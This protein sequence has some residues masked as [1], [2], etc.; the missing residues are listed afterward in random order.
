M[1]KIPSVTKIPSWYSQFSSDFDSDDDSIG[2]NSASASP[3]LLPRSDSPPSWLQGMNLDGKSPPSGE[4]GLSHTKR[5]EVV[6]AHNYLDYHLLT[7]LADDCEAF[8]RVWCEQLELVARFYSTQRMELY[9]QLARVVGSAACIEHSD[10][11]SEE[12]FQC[13]ETDPEQFQTM[14]T[15]LQQL[16]SY[17][18]A[19]AQG[20]SKLLKDP[21]LAATDSA[22]VLLPKLWTSPFFEDSAVSR[23]YSKVHKALLGKEAHQSAQAGKIASSQIT[24][25]ARVQLEF[26]H[27]CVSRV[28]ESV[29][30]H[31]V[32]HRGFHDTQD[33]ISRPIEN[34]LPAFDQAWSSG[35][36]LCE[37]DVSCAYNI[38]RTAFDCSVCSDR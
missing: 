37:C 31:L 13:I 36:H 5:P 18:K 8:N 14:F 4:F 20:F 27:E 35:V 1:K 26:L 38:N 21:Q 24:L 7:Q 32:A 16:I 11:L 9:R 15:T 23:W 2:L 29:L 10:P 12:H 3:G 17:G 33:C 19:H 6:W 25:S 34:S 22:A 28:P 30:P